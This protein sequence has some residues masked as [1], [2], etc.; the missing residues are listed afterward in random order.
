MT[1]LKS[2]ALLI[3]VALAMQGAHAVE[4]A[5]KLRQTAARL[6]APATAP[7]GC[8]RGS[9]HGGQSCVASATA[10]PRAPPA[11]VPTYFYPPPNFA[12]SP[13]PVRPFYFF[14]GAP[15]MR[16]NIS[17]DHPADFPECAG[18]SFPVILGTNGW[19]DTTI[20]P[21]CTLRL[22]G[23][24]RN[25][26]DLTQLPTN[27]PGVTIDIPARGTFDSV[28]DDFCRQTLH[29]TMDYA[30]LTVASV[31]GWD[32]NAKF[33]AVAWDSRF[34][35]QEWV[36]VDQATV[37]WV[38]NDIERRV[39]LYGIKAV[40]G[41]YSCGARAAREFANAM[42]QAWTDQYV[43]LV[44]QQSDTDR[45]EHDLWNSV[46][47]S[48][49]GWNTWSNDI[50]VDK[51]LNNQLSLMSG[52]FIKPSFYGDNVFLGV[53][54]ENFTVNQLA[55]IF[56]SPQVGLAGFAQM[57]QY[58]A[59]NPEPSLPLYNIA[60]YQPN[61]GVEQTYFLYDSWD[62]LYSGAFP[63]GTFSPGSVSRHVC[64]LSKT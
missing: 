6:G 49:Q 47:T 2:L 1:P 5:G 64:R 42:G 35:S 36:R 61:N 13:L 4:S 26:E 30:N 10:S 52:F 16:L 55:P 32:P 40:I 18:V 12:A 62:L 17:V 56:S 51:T 15:L 37:S 45:G 48:N 25:L 23:V 58:F 24:Q 59:S 57:W 39:D 63:N 11:T 27:N 31:P 41:G 20:S 50:T 44:T 14:F 54:R 46:V 33:I 34:A 8:V 38:K 43:Y 53:G 3:L 21:A 29:A 7:A 22:I 19:P 60:N 28:K 9:A